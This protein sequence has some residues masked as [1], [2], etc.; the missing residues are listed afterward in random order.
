MSPFSG[1]LRSESQ[2]NDNIRILIKIKNETKRSLAV[3]RVLNS[4][5]NI[6]KTNYE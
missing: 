6:A 5:G 4:N 1:I 3:L 2:A